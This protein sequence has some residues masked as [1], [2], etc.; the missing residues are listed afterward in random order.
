MARLYHK[1]SDWQGTGAETAL[2]SVWGV[3]RLCRVR[4]CLLVV[5]A[6]SNKMETINPAGIRRTDKI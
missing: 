6:K 2:V 4:R 3:L 5:P 1:K